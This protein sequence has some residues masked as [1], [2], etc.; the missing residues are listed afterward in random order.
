MMHQ[1]SGGWRVIGSGG[2]KKREWVSG[3]HPFAVGGFRAGVGAPNLC[4]KL[5][6]QNQFFLL[7]CCD[8]SGTRCCHN[9][10]QCVC[11][12]RLLM[13]LV[14]GRSASPP[15]DGCSCWL[16]STT[17]GV[18]RG[19][20]AAGRLTGLSDYHRGYAESPRRVDGHFSL[21]WLLTN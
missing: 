19:S 1:S 9:D 12:I 20:G 4:T 11:F 17:V 5:Y 16:F 10:A 3:L 2:R 6:S 8:R 14:S 15:A 21:L 13:K 18:S 7:V